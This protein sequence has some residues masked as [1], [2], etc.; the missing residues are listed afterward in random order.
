VQRYGKNDNDKILK[1]KHPFR[2]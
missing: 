2:Q 1:K